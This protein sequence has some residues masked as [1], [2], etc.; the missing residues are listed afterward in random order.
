[1]I[2]AP[3]S[4]FWPA[5]L[6]YDDIEDGGPFR[7]P[8]EAETTMEI[9]AELVKTLREKTGAGFGD[10][11]AALVEANGNVE[12]AVT[13]LRK[14]GTAQAAK[15]AGRSTKQG[16]I[17]SYIHLE[18]RIGVLVEVNCES[19]FVA[20]TDDFQTLVKE[21]AMQVAAFEP[22]YVRREDVPEAELEKE[23]EIYRAQLAESGKP[24]QIVDKIVEGKLGAFYEEVVLLDQL[25]I[26]DQTVKVSQLIAQVVGKTRREHRRGPLRP[27]SRRRNSSRGGR[28]PR[29]NAVPM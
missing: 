17:A 12:E 20:R 4:G 24:A 23:R 19:D 27:L 28:G 22:K 3:A 13:F 18:G 25:Y 7:A 1:M 2:P 9:K 8:H 14:R 29:Y 10:C 11:K 26:R 16:V 6:V 21:L 15:K 5:L